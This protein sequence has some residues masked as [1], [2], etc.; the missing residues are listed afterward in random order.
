MEVACCDANHVGEWN[1]EWEACEVVAD[2]GAT[3]D[4]RI[5]GDGELCR[6]VPRQFL[7]NQVPA[8]APPTGAP[9]P[10]S[11]PPPLPPPQISPHPEASLL[12]FGSLLTGDGAYGH[13]TARSY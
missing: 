12:R 5:T 10:S 9:P 4:V 7:R 8:G 6:G 13:A 1:G 3:C 11:P 2:N